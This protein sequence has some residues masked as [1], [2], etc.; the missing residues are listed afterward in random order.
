MNHQEP[1]ENEIAGPVVFA[2]MLLSL[3][4]TVIYFLSA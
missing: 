4:V 3:A 1:E 2:L